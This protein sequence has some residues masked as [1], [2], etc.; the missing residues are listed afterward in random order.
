MEGLKAQNAMEFMMTYGWAIVI[1]VVVLA[2]LYSLGFFSPSTLS[3]NVCAL[4]ANLGC[5]SAILWPNGIVQLNIQQA[6]Q[7]I[8]SVNAISCNDQGVANALPFSSPVTM[9]I[10]SNATFSVQCY[11]GSNWA[12]FNGPIGT[13]FS[14]QLFVNYTDISTGFS[15]TVSGTLIQKVK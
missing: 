11:T 13:L 2:T 10:G 8:I 14:G 15:H 3:A 5:V 7:Y 12:S 4:P 9:Q 1:L 6:T